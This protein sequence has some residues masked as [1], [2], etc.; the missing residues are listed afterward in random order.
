MCLVPQSG[1]TPE[2][3]SLISRFAVASIGSQGTVG[4]LLV[5][6][7]V[8]LP[9]SLPFPSF[10]FLKI[11]SRS[12]W[13]QLAGAYWSALALCMAVYISTNG[14]HGPTLPKSEHSRVNTFSTPPG[15]WNWLSISH[16]P[17]AAIKC[18]SKCDLFSEK[19]NPEIQIPFSSHRELS[20]TFARLC[21]VVDA[22]TTDMNEE[23]KQIEGSL[24]VLESNQKQIKLLKNKANYITNEL[25]IFEN[26]YIKLKWR[27]GGGGGVIWQRMDDEREMGIYRIREQETRTD[28]GTLWNAMD[29]LSLVWRR[30][31]EFK[32]HESFTLPPTLLFLFVIAHDCMELEQLCRLPI[33]FFFLNI[34]L[35]LFPLFKWQTASCALDCFYFTKYKLFSPHHLSLLFQIF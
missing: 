29:L 10:R 30:S 8:S 6:G 2:Q 35:K 12:C 27:G 15:N 14:C 18:N 33:P 17:I 11:F 23:L 4:G 22:A 24:T 21:R 32:H 7:F 5:G 26:N 13:K 28:Y 3:L 19:R 25:E 34:F 20:S 1:I 16:R 31:L 9:V